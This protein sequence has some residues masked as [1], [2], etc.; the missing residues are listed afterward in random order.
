MGVEVVD[1]RP[2]EIRC[3]DGT[4]A[5]IYDFGLKAPEDTEEREEL[6]KLFSDTFQAVWE[7][8]PSPTA[9]RAG[10]AWQA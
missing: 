5:Y 6:R 2:Y 7:G 3:D 1:E 9:E 8:G 4:A 10:P